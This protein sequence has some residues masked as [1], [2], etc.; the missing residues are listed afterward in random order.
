MEVQFS[1]KYFV[2]F[3][4]YVYDNIYSQYEHFPR[5]S[6]FIC[7][8]AAHCVSSSPL[9]FYKHPVSHCHEALPPGDQ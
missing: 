9:H 4:L 1:F 7:P 8:S 6:L 3:F 2:Y 5:V